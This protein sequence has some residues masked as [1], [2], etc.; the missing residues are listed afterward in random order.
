MPDLAK[1]AANFPE[2]E[3]EREREREFEQATFAVERG[4]LSIK[5]ESDGGEKKRQRSWT[6]QC[7]GER[8]NYPPALPLSL[9]LS[10]A[11]G[12]TCHKANEVHF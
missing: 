9:S 4:L 6:V 8:M 11:V 12:V 5:R 2:R 3:R 10:F 1:T 7:I